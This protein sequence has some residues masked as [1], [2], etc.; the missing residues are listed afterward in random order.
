MCNGKCGAKPLQFQS[1]G[2]VGCV[3]FCKTFRTGIYRLGNTGWLV[4]KYRVQS[5]LCSG[6][7][8]GGRRTWKDGASEHHLMISNQTYLR[9]SEHAGQS[10]LSLLRTW[11][12]GFIHNAFNE[13]YKQ[14][15]YAASAVCARGRVAELGG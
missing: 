14:G 6:S 7:L 5:V 1:K 12:F 9:R 11:W 10:T 15:W 3:M 13:R 4:H 2:F 8:V